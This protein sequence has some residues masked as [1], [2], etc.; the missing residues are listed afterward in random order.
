MTPTELKRRTRLF[1]VAVIELVETLPAN[2]KGK[3]LGD[4][5]F[6]A[7]ASVG[8]N[9]RAACKARSRAEFVAK[10]G[11]VEEEAD[12]CQYW[13]RLLIDTGLVDEA[14]IDNLRQEAKELTAI[15]ASS[16][17]SARMSK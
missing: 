7:A 10:I 3:I 9:Y 11:I 12:E 1:A 5:L 14:E 13:L 15:M 17:K 2:R 6:R 8:A 4:Q 16:R